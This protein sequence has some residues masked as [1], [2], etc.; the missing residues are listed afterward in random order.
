MIKVIDGKNVNDLYVEGLHWMRATGVE[1]DT[2]NGKALVSP[3]PVM[4]IYHRP[5]ERVLFDARRNANPFFHLAEAIWMLAGSNDAKWI[6]QYNKQMLTYSDDSLTLRGAYGYRW[7]K[8]WGIDQIDAVIY[9]LKKDHTTRKAVLSMWDAGEDLGTSSKDTPCN[10]TIYFRLNAG[11]LD[12]TLCC[13]SN[14]LVWGAYGANAV[15]FSILHEYISRACD[16]PQGKMYQLSNNFHIYE[17][18]WPLM[19]P[20]PLINLDPYETTL[21]KLLRQDAIQVIPLFKHM[22]FARDFIDD[23]Q[24]IVMGK[25][26]YVETRFLR[27]V[28]VPMLD[29]Y[30]VRDS[31]AAGECVA[32][33]PDCDWKQ[34]A[35]QWL[36]RRHENARRSESSTEAT[37]P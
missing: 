15:H 31:D 26:A 18:H 34:A 33:I 6:A 36:I 27:T 28:A 11:F 32:A 7:R 12:M 30:R 16:L 21:P 24:K 17:P 14:D 29:A 13:R 37:Q 5:W 8:Q 19:A 22:H 10:T 35:S 20:T 9:M 1:E 23:C 2:R 25:L 3:W 4:S